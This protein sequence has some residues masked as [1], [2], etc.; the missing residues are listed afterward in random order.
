MGG[1]KLSVRP[2]IM[3]LKATNGT[4]LNG[5]RIDDMVRTPPKPASVMPA[6]MPFF[7]QHS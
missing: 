2:Y 1:V 5:D 4:F 3:D 7:L 6:S